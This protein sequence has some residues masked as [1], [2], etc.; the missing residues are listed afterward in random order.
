MTALWKQLLVVSVVL[1]SVRPSYA[2]DNAEFLAKFFDS[3]LSSVDQNDDGSI[4]CLPTDVAGPAR[5]EV[6]SVYEGGEEVDPDDLQFRT[7]R[8]ATVQVRAT[9][10]PVYLVLT[11]REPVAWELI[12]EDGAKLAAVF[13]SA[14]YTPM[15]LG[16]PDDVPVGLSFAK[17]TGLP[18]YRPCELP[19]DRQ[20]NKRLEKGEFYYSNERSASRLTD[21][22]LETGDFTVGDFQAYIP[23]RGSTVK[24]IVVPDG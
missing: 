16:V 19:D 23:D 12:L 17:S 15:I 10:T 4:R 22:L 5:I 11:S 9:D 1:F 21:L 2:D 14:Y 20:M 3:T 24:V 6:V 18:D 8:L 7:L 13:L